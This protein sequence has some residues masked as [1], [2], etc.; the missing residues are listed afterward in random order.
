MV[1]SNSTLRA[2]FPLDAE[3]V[4][5]VGDDGALLGQRGV[6]SAQQLGY[7]GALHTV[8]ALPDGRLYVGG[9]GGAILTRRF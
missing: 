6:F 4:L 9:N 7:G 2:V 3:R 1:P 5:V 8:F